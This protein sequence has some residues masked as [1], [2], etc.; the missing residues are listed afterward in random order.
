[1]AEPHTM[2]RLRADI[3]SGRTRDK[4]SA[5]DPAASPLGTDDEAAGTP[6]SPA[7]VAL[8]VASRPGGAPPDSGTTRAGTT[9][10]E[11]TQAETTQAMQPSPGRAGATTGE[12]AR[13]AS[14]LNPSAR[15]VNRTI[16]IGAAV[17]LV[18][19]ALVILVVGT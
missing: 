10:A 5:P 3:D 15:T 9:Q 2:A 17:V 19:A 12:D 6:A 18:L 8:A 11:T 4:V 14:G 1:M 7:R 13:P 16:L